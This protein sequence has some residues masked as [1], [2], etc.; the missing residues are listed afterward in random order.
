MKT[1]HEGRIA[2]TARFIAARLE[3]E[4][5]VFLTLPHD[6]HNVCRLDRILAYMDR[7]CGKYFVQSST[8]WNYL[9]VKK[10][11]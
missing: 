2:N 4:P 1:L 3:K 9:I 5:E 10:R 7:Y 11:V 6:W 8:A